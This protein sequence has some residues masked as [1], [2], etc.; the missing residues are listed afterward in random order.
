[1]PRE[2]LK[3]GEW[4]VITT[5]KRDKSHVAKARIRDRDGKLRLVE[6]TGVS[7]D[8]ARRKL[9]AKLVE[10]VAPEGEK[11]GQLSKRSTVSELAEY[12]LA[13]KETSTSVGESTLSLYRS[14]W[15]SVCEDALGDL[16]I[17]ELTAGAVDAFLRSVA[18]RAPSR[19]R[20]ARIVLSGMFSMATRLD[21]ID[22]NLVRETKVP[23]PK[24][25][26]VRPVTLEELT[27]I[28]AAVD[29]YCRHETVDAEGVVRRKYGPKPGADLQDQMD[30][31]MATGVRISELLAL[32]WDDVH[33]DADV[34][35]IVVNA[36]LVQPRS[37]G[38]KLIRQPHR[39]GDAPP[40][41]IVIPKFAVDIL[42][43]RREALTFNNP[44]GAVFV[45]STGNWVSP[46]NVRRCWRGALGKDFDWVTPHSFRRTVAT[47]VKAQYGVE[48]A[49]AQLGH[50]NTAVT[51]AHYIQR[52]NS[53][54]DMT[55]A[56]NTFAP[57][58][59]QSVG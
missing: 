57:S 53:A 59:R 42:R 40:L 10:R 54:P 23:R 32:L 4:G 26:P 44:N 17:T 58:E 47:L 9:Q 22:H 48:A 20:L 14:A 5:T 28:R 39:K 55:E 7:A 6:A 35:T 18:V 21:L 1:M 11:D 41:T 30:L 50:A 27:D 36:T 46:A 52:M 37:A 38:E 33:L 29:L 31:L 16:R 49:Q 56:L 13:E 51:E 45:T 43:R 15:R 12:W 34:P 24:R 25:K 3:P 8:E 2:R 19:A